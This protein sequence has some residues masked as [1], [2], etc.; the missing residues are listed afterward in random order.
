MKPILSFVGKSE[1]GK[2]TLL[3]EI[4]TDLKQRGLK[5]AIIK[6]T[7]KFELDKQGKDSWR[8]HQ[9]G[10]DTVVVSSREELA[11][12]KKA[13][14]SLTP[15]EIAHFIDPDVDLILTEGFKKS[16]TMKI[17]VHRKEQGTGLLVPPEQ[18]LAVVTDEPL[19]INLPQFNRDDTK[20]LAN[21]IEKWLRKQPK[22][23]IE[24]FVNNSFV[25]LN[26]FVKD[27]ITK[28]IVGMV[29][30][31]KGIGDINSIRIALKKK[32]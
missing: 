18:L 22:D 32:L 10:A 13:D 8:L 24:L 5:I 11:V 29:S 31:L 30:S 16:N 25:P 19:D 26:I 3:V 4:I 27:I 17:E 23:E 28:T 20:G 9:L 2:T 14:H 7:Q 1:S 12:M 6:H 15:Q 21:L